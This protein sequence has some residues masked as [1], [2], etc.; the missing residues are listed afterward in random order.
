MLGHGVGYSVGE[1]VKMFR[2]VN[3][4]PNIDLLAKVGPRRKCDIDYYVLKDVSHYMK[5]L[6]TMEELLKV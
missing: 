2:E 1:I 4:I 6:Y 5:N 3:N